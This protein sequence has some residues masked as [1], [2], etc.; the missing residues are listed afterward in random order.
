MLIKG[1]KSLETSLK[2][3]E[4]GVQNLRQLLETLERA[5]KVLLQGANP[6]ETFNSY[7]FIEII[8]K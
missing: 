5:E 1:A 4:D 7:Y 2:P 6:I 3:Q 8:N